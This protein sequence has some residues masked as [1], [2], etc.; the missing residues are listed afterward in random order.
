MMKRSIIILSV[1]IFKF[2][3]LQADLVWS[4]ESGWGAEGG[5]LEL[6]IDKTPTAHNALEAMNLARQAQEEKDYRAAINLYQQ[7]YNTCPNSILAPEALYQVGLIRMER[8]EFNKA[9]RIFEKIITDYPNYPKFDKIIETQFK[10]ASQLQVGRRPY[11]WGIIPGFKDYRASMKFFESIVAN[12]PYSR[13]APYALMNMAI[14]AEESGKH[15]D[16]IDALDRLISEYPDSTLAPEA[17]LMLSRVYM[18]LIQGPNYDQGTTMEAVNHYD[19]FLFLYPNNPA[20]KEAEEGL[21]CA[22]DVQAE[23]K[24]VMGDFYYQRRNSPQA[25]RVFYNEAISIAPNSFTAQV[26]RER[27]EKIENGELAPPCFADVIFGRYERECTPPYLE[28]EEPVK[29]SGKKKC[30]GLFSFFKKK[31]DKG[32]S[33]QASAQQKAAVKDESSDE[34][35]FAEAAAED[36]MIAQEAS[37][38]S[39]STAMGERLRALKR[40]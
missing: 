35:L 11:Y 16:A 39:A 32:T 4:R 21:A 30:W 14:L 17:Y 10:I 8:C 1:L 34:D 33:Q 12:A 36:R 15:T 9:F 23:S 19:D 29:L 24:L 13:Y 18:G 27:L 5:V 25:A 28:R 38:E 26:A 6:I 3:T 7:V 40:K 22:R 20:V 31:K 2:A 37:K